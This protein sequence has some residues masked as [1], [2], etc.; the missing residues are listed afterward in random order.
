M[1]Y[2]QNPIN[3]Y[4]CEVCA[5]HTVTIDRE[6]GVTPFMLRCRATKD[7]GGSA[8]SQ[9][10]S[11]PQ[12]LTPSYEWRK[13]TK[14]EYFQQDKE[15]REHVDKGGLL[16]Y[17]LDL[18]KEDRPAKRVVATPLKQQRLARKLNRQQL[19]RA[20]K[21]LAGRRLTPDELAMIH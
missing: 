6:P 19:I 7:C 15:T 21:A 3:V 1:S 5:G 4:I 10:Y 14:T 16:V 9:F 20:A 8:F 12:D 2:P 18:S 11:V 17:P 13:P